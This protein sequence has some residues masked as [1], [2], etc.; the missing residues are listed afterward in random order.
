MATKTNEVAKLW[1]AERAATGK[2]VVIINKNWDGS[3]FYIKLTPYMVSWIEAAGATTYTQAE[4]TA[5]HGVV[6]ANWE[7]ILTCDPATTSSCD[8]EFDTANADAAADFRT[9]VSAA[10]VTESARA[11]SYYS[12]S[13]V[14]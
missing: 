14:L 7:G 11:C 13:Q 3:K 8:I 6:A 12:S 2:K 1:N 9:L 4:A 5:N 10:D